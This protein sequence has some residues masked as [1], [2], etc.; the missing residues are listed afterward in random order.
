MFI[1]SEV[2]ARLTCFKLV[3]NMIK[4]SIFIFG[5]LSKAIDF[6]GK[7]KELTT[8]GFYP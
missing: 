4:T 3:Y 6:E 5:L 8:I 2:E 1:S 7:I